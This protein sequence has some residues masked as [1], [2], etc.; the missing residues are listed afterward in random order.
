MEGKVDFGAT[1]AYLNQEE[2]AAAPGKIL[3][4]PTCIGA[5]AIIYHL[6]ENPD[7]RFSPSL[8]AKTF[9]GR[10]GS[11][12]DPEMVALNAGPELPDRPIQVVYRSDSSGTNFILSDY[13]SKVD[14]DWSAQ[15]GRG[16]KIKWPSG[17]GA[18]G[19]E[20]VLA[21]VMRIPGSVGYV[22]LNYARQKNLPVAAIQNRAGRFIDPTPAA[23][24][25]AAAMEL[26]SD[27]RVSITDTTAVD[28]YPISG[29]TYLIVYRELSLTTPGRDKA[30]ELFHFLRW[31]IREGQAF[32]VPLHFAPLPSDSLDRLNR[33]I[34]SITHEGRVLA[35]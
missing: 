2:M 17:V 13:L 20:G 10:I 28:G 9:G 19:N 30:Q 14:A 12:R 3:H 26:P 18:E 35:P 32:A 16:K 33:L 29:F 21:M 24:S 11:W 22:S 7:L 8:L 15:V 25:A 4:I 23:V 27:L 1:D 31:A 34:D 5:V 6:P